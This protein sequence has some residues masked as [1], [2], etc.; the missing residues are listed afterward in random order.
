MY[1]LRRLDLVANSPLDFAVAKQHL[2]LTH[3]RDDTYISKQLI[4]AAA[5][6]AEMATHRQLLTATWELTLDRPPRLGDYGSGSYGDGEYAYLTSTPRTRERLLLP[7]APLQ[8]VNSITYI[9]TAGDEQTWDEDNYI[10]SVGKEPAEISLAHG[11]TWPQTLRVQNAFTVNF[12]CGYGDD[13]SA[14]PTLLKQGMLLHI[15]HLYLNRE[16]IVTDA[17]VAVAELPMA[18]REIFQQFGVGDDFD[19]YDVAAPCDSATYGRW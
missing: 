3:D 10:V 7:M 5:E 12:D 2:R 9:D 15:G 13:E 19:N 16:T 8:Q 1:G 11:K 4:T 14:I 18:T 6:A 17:R